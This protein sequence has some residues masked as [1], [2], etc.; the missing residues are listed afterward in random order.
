MG[1]STASSTVRYLAINYKFPIDENKYVDT[2]QTA[3][4]SSY[5]SNYKDGI[6]F[7]ENWSGPLFYTLSK[8][9]AR[10]TAFNHVNPVYLVDMFMSANATSSD[11]IEFSLEEFNIDNSDAVSIFGKSRLSNTV[12]ITQSGGRKYFNRGYDINLASSANGDN[13]SSLTIL[14]YKD[15]SNRRLLQ[16]SLFNTF[17]MSSFTLTINDP[18]NFLN[19]GSYSSFRLAFNK[20]FSSGVRG[21][22]RIFYL[23]NNYT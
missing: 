11:Y 5:P 22:I 8:Y 15:R 23:G 16:D 21:Y 17:I 7:T 3:S 9:S 19:S 4:V 13:N 12:N 2:P 10:Y 1:K 14:G 20:S 18:T 6:C